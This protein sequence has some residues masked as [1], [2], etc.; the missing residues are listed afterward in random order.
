MPAHH[1]TAALGRK[2]APASTLLLTHLNGANGS[3]SLKDSSRFARPV[4]P[5]GSAALSTA[6]HAFGASSLYSPDTASGASIPDAADLRALGGVRFWVLPHTDSFAGAEK[7]WFSKWD[8][9]LSTSMLTIGMIGA[10]GALYFYTSDG[11]Q[12]F[13]GSP[14]SPAIQNDGTWRFVAFEYHDDTRSASLWIGKKGDATA[15]RVLHQDARKNSASTAPVRFCIDAAGVGG[16]KGWIDE[17]EIYSG[18][19][20]GDVSSIPVPSAPF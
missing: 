17:V 16:A 19:R 7:E 4:A 8:G 14:S 5:V 6:Q 9:N 11:Y 13:F 12:F 18:A 1:A 20:Y 2:P 15:Q 10:S 3:T